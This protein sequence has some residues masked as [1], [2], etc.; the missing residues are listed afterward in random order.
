MRTLT[1]FFGILCLLAPSVAHAKRIDK[2]S[3]GELIA[4]LKNSD[5]PERRVQAA[6]RLGETGAR[7]ATAALGSVCSTQPPSELCVASVSALSDLGT[8][9]A[10]T[11]VQKILEL[12]SAPSQ[13]RRQALTVLMQ[14]DQN[15]LRESIPMLFSVYSSLSTELLSELMVSARLLELSELADAAVFIASDG[16]L[17]LAARVSALDTA[18]HFGPPRLFEAHKS[19]LS[20]QDSKLRARC[21]E[22]LGAPGLPA[23]TLVPLLKQVVRQDPEGYVRS[24]AIEALAHYTHPDL[25]SLLH[26]RLH[27]DRHPVAF[28]TMLDLAVTLSDK[29]SVPH[30]SQ[31]LEEYSQMR[32]EQI[33]IVVQKLAHLGDPSAIPSIFIVEQ[34]H[35]GTE[36]AKLCR[37]V[38]TA[39]E[40]DLFDAETMLTNVPDNPR[41]PIVPWNPKL[42]DAQ[43][44]SLTVQ[45]TSKGLSYIH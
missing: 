26:E 15:R 45:G 4:E 43:I 36:L 27:V 19:L 41:L 14:A 6:Q 13:G 18:E 40:T 7:E 28:Q 12:E 34:R 2:M 31:L 44:P 23:S 20:A 30:L 3:T 38:V 5:K 32:K 24:S 9:E 33:E 22:S 16:K 29:S 11:R 8:T 35:Q 10:I 21:A 42:P 17:D 37:T 25:L 39:L 1:T